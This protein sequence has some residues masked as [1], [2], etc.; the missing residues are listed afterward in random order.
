[1]DKKK[2]TQSSVSLPEAEGPTLGWLLR[3]E[4]GEGPHGRMFHRTIAPVYCFMRAR[5]RAPV[6]QGPSGP[7]WLYCC[8]RAR[9]RAPVGQGPSGPGWL[10]TALGFESGRV[11]ASGTAW[12][13]LWWRLWCL[14]HHHANREINRATCLIGAGLFE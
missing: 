8:M 14:I 2:P 3:R 9:H 11:I 6:G 13:G 12:A 5:H 7:G 10:A 4:G 1:M